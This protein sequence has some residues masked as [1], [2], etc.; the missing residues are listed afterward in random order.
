MRMNRGTLITLAALVIIIIAVLIL[1]NQQANAPTVTATPSNV[2][3]SVLPADTIIG[4]IMQVQ[5]RDN[6]TGV[7]T[8]LAKASDGVWSIDATNTTDR[9]TD[10]TAAAAPATSLA[11]LMY[12]N[13]FTS[14]QLSQFG[15]ANPHYT[16]LVYLSDGNHYTIHI[17][18][19][20]ATGGRYYAVIESGTGEAS[21]IPSADLLTL[22]TEEAESTATVDP[23][24]AMFAEPTQALLAHPL[25][26]LSGTQTI[27]LIPQTT[28][29]TL[30]ALLTFPPYVPAPTPTA[31][32]TST[33]NPL[34]EVDMTATAQ[35]L[36]D[37]LTATADAF[38]VPAETAE[39]TE[40]ATAEAEL[41]VETTPES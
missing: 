36:Y 7:Y 21:L 39:A 37:S 9:E 4:S 25:V 19:P 31:L 1:N 14:D 28:I 20:A 41:T 15:L 27:Y 13:T 5:V 33:P 12:N 23:M 3:G 11:G 18:D 8:V 34:S 24:L 38:I 22:A 40:A 35:S 26:T 30:T 17:G 2:S 16:L 6:T 32:P 29:N 10:Q